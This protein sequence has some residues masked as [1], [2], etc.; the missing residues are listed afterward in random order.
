MA[1]RTNVILYVVHDDELIT[2]TTLP[3]VFDSSAIALWAQ[4]QD[5]VCTGLVVSVAQWVTNSLTLYHVT[6]GGRQWRGEGATTVLLEQTYSSCIFDMAM[7]SL[8]SSSFSSSSSSTSEEMMEEEKDKE[9]LCTMISHIDGSV[10]IL[11]SSLPSSC[12]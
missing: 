5:G 12:E 1:T 6:D 8:S 3:T 10:R 2:I 7:L 9:I 4:S 11:S